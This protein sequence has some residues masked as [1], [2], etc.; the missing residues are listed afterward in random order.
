MEIRK[1]V[2]ED[3]DEVLQLFA[4]ARQF[5]RENGNPDQWGTT[6]PPRDIVVSDIEQGRCYLCT[7]EG[8]AVATFYFALETDHDY[9]AIYEGA[10]LNDEPYAV[11][12]RVASP[13]RKKG[14]ATFCVKWCLEH[15]GGNLR[16]DTH[17][18]NIPMQ[19]MLEKNGFTRC[20]I[21]HPHYG[22][23]RIGFQKNVSAVAAHEL[24]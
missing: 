11:M 3:L 8:R 20:G 16:I 14:A 2:M 6:Y 24:R 22:T 13:G 1:A 21:I 10:W 23:E 4:E 18:D 17:Q 7:D 9:D 12:H 15:C 5:M 19:R